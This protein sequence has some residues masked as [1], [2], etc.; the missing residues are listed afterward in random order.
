MPAV[1]GG[2]AD[3]DRAA[4]PA[5]TYS[6]GTDG[7]GRPAALSAAL[8]REPE[9]VVDRANELAPHLPDELHR[10][11]R[12]MVGKVQNDATG[13]AFGAFGGHSVRR[14][15][16]APEALVGP[17]RCRCLVDQ[18]ED[19]PAEQDLAAADKAAGDGTAGVV[20]A[21]ELDAAIAARRDRLVVV[22]LPPGLGAPRVGRPL[23]AARR[24]ERTAARSTGRDHGSDLRV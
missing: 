8:S 3:A 12:V 17:P 10:I 24:A 13:R 16:W 9:E 2:D 18:P 5:A 14:D 15:T 6:E 7:P 4:R 1:C 23:G 11:S 21:A 19:V 20:V 22:R